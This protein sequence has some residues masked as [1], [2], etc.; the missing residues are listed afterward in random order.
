MKNIDLKTVKS[1][2]D[3]WLRYD[4]SGMKKEEIIEMF[5]SYFSIFPWSSL[6]KFAKGFDMGC[7][8]ILINKRRCYISSNKFWVIQHL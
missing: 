2:G 5:K 3:E 7:G 8:K 6:S 1:F 4:Q